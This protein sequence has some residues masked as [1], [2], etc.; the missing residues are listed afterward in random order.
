MGSASNIR[1]KE[2]FLISSL[3]SGVSLRDW[4]G[5]TSRCKE[6]LECQPEGLQEGKKAQFLQAQVRQGYNFGID[7]IH[8][9]AMPKSKMSSPWQP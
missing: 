7:R 9:N 3:I 6:E 2:E 1:R 5:H 8:K 4:K